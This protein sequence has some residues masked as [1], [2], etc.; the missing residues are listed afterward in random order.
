MERGGGRVRRLLRR[1]GRLIGC[2]VVGCMIVIGRSE[3]MVGEV[4]T[5]VGEIVV[6]TASLKVVVVD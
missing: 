4:E 5:V 6:G 2:I 1:V 3:M